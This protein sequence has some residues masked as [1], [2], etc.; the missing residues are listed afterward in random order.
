MTHLFLVWLKVKRDREGTG[1]GHL[2]N[3]L[4][5]HLVSR[6]TSLHQLFPAAMYTHLTPSPTTPHLLKSSLYPSYIGPLGCHAYQCIMSN[7]GEG[8]GDRGGEAQKQRRSIQGGLG[9]AARLGQQS[10][11]IPTV[12]LL[13][14]WVVI[15]RSWTLS[16]ARRTE[17][18]NESP[19]NCAP[20][21]LLISSPVSHLLL[22]HCSAAPS[23]LSRP[24]PW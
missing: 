14:H 13:L 22:P 16:P 12:G 7:G 23:S 6:H 20:P 24:L 8:K 15:N 21:T 3:T 18:V 5:P 2:W 1:A 4:G 17:R 19:K 11:S 10:G 9:R